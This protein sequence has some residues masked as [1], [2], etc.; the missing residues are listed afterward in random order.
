MLS[1]EL[2][3]IIRRKISKLQIIVY[4][5]FTLV[6]YGLYISGQ[7]NKT[8]NLREAANLK[9]VCWIQCIGVRSFVFSKF[10]IFVSKYRHKYNK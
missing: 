1:I 8:L 4:Y 6:Y 9:D 5:D 3:A 2:K 7:K 10:E